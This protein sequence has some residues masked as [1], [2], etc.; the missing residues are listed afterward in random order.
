M[1]TIYKCT[2]PS[3]R[4]YIGFTSKSFARRRIQHL[5]A[6]KSGS[7]YAFHRAIRKY[8]DDMRWE[9]LGVVDSLESARSLEKSL[10]SQHESFGKGY[11]M[12][13]GGEG[14]I[15]TSFS[16]SEESREKISK[17]NARYW[18]NRPRSEETKRKLSLAQRGV[19]KGPFTPEHRANLRIAALKR[20][21]S[22]R[23]G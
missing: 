15:G 1:F 5:S 20:Y 16:H 10:I 22:K 14:Q 21:A 19:P 8:G 9:I 23:V 17:N 13:A 7:T 2:S 3:N 4:V 18:A 6:A 11:N 12:T